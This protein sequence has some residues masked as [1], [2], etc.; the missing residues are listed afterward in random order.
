MKGRYQ[1]VEKKGRDNL[2]K[3]DQEAVKLFFGRN[4]QVLLPFAELIEESKL[5]VYDFIM[6]TGK[7]LIELILRMSVENLI[8]PPHSGKAQGEVY[9]YGS[10]PGTVVLA[11]RK[12]RGDKPR[13]RKK[14]GGRGA[15]VEVPAY[16]AMQDD[17]ALS[18]RMLSL[19]MK[20]VSTRNY[21]GVIGE[22]ADTVGVSKSNVSRHFI[23]AGMAEL[24]RLLERRFDDVDILI[25][26][27]DGQ[28]FGG[29]RVIS[30]VGV[31]D[32]GFKHVLGL[33]PGAT[34]NAAVVK[35]LLEDLVERGVKPG[36]RRLFVID[37]AKALRKGIDLVYGADNPVQRCRIHK[38]R[39]VMA[40]LPADLQG[41]VGSVMKAAY[42]LPAAEGMK[43]LKQ[44]AKWL[45]AEHPNAAAS[46][47]EG[48]SETF[49]VNRLE[50]PP[51][52]RRCLGSTNL[53]ESPRSGVRMRTR[54][55]SLWRSQE[56][57]MY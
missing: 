37:G 13:L 12:L 24:K 20:G 50:L 1:V 45:E 29:H 18:A 27:L 17:A 6:V 25:I 14:G 30:A 38:S 51:S 49:T 33:Y 11:D 43:K 2:S 36:R 26:Y 47:L 22:M 16:A 48:L 46:L 41:Q 55:V 40:H 53:I 10:Q 56:R 4:G 23:E 19:L 35:S 42:R 15:E 28:E 5:A 9:R 44:Q 8:G 21:E 52:L 34:E 32:K 39:N 7:A 57:V 31:D 54:R 3:K